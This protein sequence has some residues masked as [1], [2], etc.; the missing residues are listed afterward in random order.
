MKDNELKRNGS[1]YID[2]PC[3]KAVT[4][5]PRPGE[6]WIHGKSGAQM[7][8]LANVNG[9]CPTLRLSAMGGEGLIPVTSKTVMYVKPIMI[10]YC[11]DNLLTDFVKIVKGEELMKVQKAIIR[12]LGLLKGLVSMENEMAIETTLIQKIEVLEEEREAL[13]EENKVIRAHVDSLKKSLAEAEAPKTESDQMKSME[14]VYN[15][16]ITC[17][18]QEIVKLSIYKDMYMDVI[19]RLVSMRGG[20]VAND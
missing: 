2:E 19:N 18:Q 3:Y 5:P 8:V 14:K 13:R 6:I 17:M 11:F 20:A 15:E 4:A 7:L 12:E 16:A 9:V 10:G 1:G